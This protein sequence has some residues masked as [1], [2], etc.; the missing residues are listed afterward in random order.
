MVRQKRK[1][2]RVSSQIKISDGVETS[3]QNYRQFQ[4]HQADQREAHARNSVAASGDQEQSLGDE[5]TS[6]LT[7]NELKINHLVSMSTPPSAEKM[8]QQKGNLS[9]NKSQQIQVDRF[10]AE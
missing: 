6:S 10:D 3:L 9:P 7:Q 1:T 2:V 5:R 4:R 8:N